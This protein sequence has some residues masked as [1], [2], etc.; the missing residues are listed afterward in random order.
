MLKHIVTHPGTGTEIV[1]QICKSLGAK[2]I[3]NKLEQAQKAR[4]D[5]LILL[6]GTDIDT[7]FYG[8]RH[9]LAYSPDRNRDAIEWYLVR[10]AFNRNVPV[11]GICRGHQMLAVAAGGSLWQDVERQGATKRHYAAHQLV[12]VQGPLDLHIPSRKVNS[13]HHQAIRRMPFEFHIMARSPDGLVESIWTPG[14]L[15]VQFHPELLYPNNP[16]W[17]SLFEWFIKNRLA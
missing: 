6:G 14:Y 3:V 15:G 5:G 17:I 2:L 10:Q 11:L 1:A 7:R 9:T 12:E 16:K 4:F 13:Y 8:E